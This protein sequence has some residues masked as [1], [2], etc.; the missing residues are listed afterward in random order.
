MVRAAS[1]AV[2]AGA[3]LTVVLSSTS[4]KVVP[5]AHPLELTHSPPILA[6]VA[7]VA[8]S[9]PASCAK[10]A[11]ATARESAAIFAALPTKTWGAA[12][13]SISV[14]VAARSV[15]L[16]GDT[17]SDGRFAH[18][19]AITQNRGCLHVS[20]GGAQLLPNDN[21]SH[22]YWIQSAVTVSPTRVDVRARTVTLT[23]TKAWAFKDGGFD[24]TAFPRLNAAGDLTFAY[25]DAKVATPIPDPGPMYIYGP[26]TSGM[27]GTPT[28][29]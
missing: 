20:H 23:G 19:T 28:R 4:V 3:A 18:S 5:A 17:F 6:Q 29:S 27:A 13:G 22:I 16:Y 1:L 25:W 26:T 7:L 24:R 15:W 9:V 14:K 12:D 8:R 21:V 10:K 11:P 2:M